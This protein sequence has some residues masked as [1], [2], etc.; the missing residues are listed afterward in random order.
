MPYHADAE[1]SLTMCNHFDQSRTDKHI[2]MGRNTI[3]RF[4]FS[5][6]ADNVRLTNVYIIIIIIIIIDIAR[7]MKSS[8]FLLNRKV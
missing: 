8:N 6:D 2:Q 4:R 7:H 5:S 1:K 3:L